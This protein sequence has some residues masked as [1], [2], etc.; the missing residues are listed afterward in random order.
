MCN[1]TVLKPTYNNITT[2]FLITCW[3]NFHNFVIIS[4]KV[5][6]PEIKKTLIFNKDILKNACL[7]QYPPPRTPS[8]S[9]FCNFGIFGIACVKDSNVTW[10]LW[11]HGAFFF[12]NICNWCCS[13]PEVGSLLYTC[14]QGSW[15]TVAWSPLATNIF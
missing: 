2:H 14:I 5:I 11:N 4:L 8:F 6:G 10:K 13:V 7:T 15:N 9:F 3:C 12:L 1:L